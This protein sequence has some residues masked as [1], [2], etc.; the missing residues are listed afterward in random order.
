MTKEDFR[1]RWGHGFNTLSDADQQELLN[2]A[3]SIRISDDDKVKFLIRF[4]DWHTEKQATGNE[5]ANL[6]GSA[7][8]FLKS[9]HSII[10]VHDAMDKAVKSDFPPDD[11]GLRELAID[12]YPEANYSNFRE[13]RAQFVNDCKFLIAKFKLG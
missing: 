11:N 10:N 8:R 9:A 2:D 3:Q 1:Q 6:I 12:K 4:Y 13:R 5:F 7:R